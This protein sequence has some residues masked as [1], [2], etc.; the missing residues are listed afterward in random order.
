LSLSSQNL[1]SLTFFAY[2]Q[3]VAF[4]LTPP[5]WNLLAWRLPFFLGFSCPPPTR[6]SCCSSP[7][8]FSACQFIHSPGLMALVSSSV[9]SPPPFPRLAFRSFCLVGCIRLLTPFPPRPTFG[10]PNGAPLR[11][12]SVPLTDLTSIELFVQRNSLPEIAFPDFRHSLVTRSWC[13]LLVPSLLFCFFLSFCPNH[14][15][16]I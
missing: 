16:G 6:P 9:A 8:F 15:P 7:P 2:C 11:S 10:V 5:P 1:V 3:V 13:H 14:L 4:N 12:A